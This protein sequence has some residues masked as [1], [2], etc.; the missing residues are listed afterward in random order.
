MI[1]LIRIFSQA[2][3]HQILCFKTEYPEFSLGS[4]WLFLLWLRK[5]YFLIG[6]LTGKPC[7]IY[8]FCPHKGREQ[9]HWEAAVATRE[10][11]GWESQNLA[12]ELDS[13]TYQ[14][15]EFCQVKSIR[16]KL[17][18]RVQWKVFVSRLGS[19]EPKQWLLPRRK[20]SSKVRTGG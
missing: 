5:F 12:P 8:A 13:T 20:T 4:L 16:S 2:T 9:T 15:Y 1:D 19:S 18:Q 14:L 7:I 10:T 17:T 3:C 6:K 11:Q